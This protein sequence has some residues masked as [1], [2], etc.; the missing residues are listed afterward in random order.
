[1]L[2]LINNR[3]FK[4]MRA[5]FNNE[6]YRRAVMSDASNVEIMRKIPLQYGVRTT[7]IWYML[8][9]CMY[10]LLV[11][12]DKLDNMHTAHLNL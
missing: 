1:M 2:A 7:N 8:I 10:V 3:D 9:Y 6:C 5:I 12:A 4:A 11:N